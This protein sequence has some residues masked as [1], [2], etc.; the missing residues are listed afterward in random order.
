M[1]KTFLAARAEML[2]FLRSEG[3]KVKSDLKFPHAISP[4][5]RV[6]LYFKPQAVYIGEGIS[7]MGDTRSMWIDIRDVDGPTFM[8]AVEE[9]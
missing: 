3:W 8:R 2:A 5:G 4:N 6:H 7:S 1:R 9:F